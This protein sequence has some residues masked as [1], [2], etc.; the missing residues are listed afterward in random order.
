MEIFYLKNLMAK[1]SIFKY[2]YPLTY[3]KIEGLNLSEIKLIEQKYEKEFSQIIKEFLFLGGKNFFCFVSSPNYWVGLE[4]YTVQFD[5]TLFKGNFQATQITINNQII[6][7]SYAEG[8]FFYTDFSSEN[9]PVYF[10]VEKAEGYSVEKTF[11]TFSD[12]IEY[13]IQKEEEKTGS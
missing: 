10:Y 5:P 3:E 1:K 2:A 12:M 7:L 8:C 13:Y 6:I 4:L 11:D 9:P